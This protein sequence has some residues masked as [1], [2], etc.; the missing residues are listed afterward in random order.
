MKKVL[1]VFGSYADQRQ[2]FFD[3]YMSPRNQEYADKHGFE[4][5]ELKDDLYKYRGNY[6]WLKF[7]ILEQMLEEGYVTDGDIVTHL[8]A[9]MCIANID[10]LYQ[11]NK[12][13]SYSIDSGNTHCMGNYS[14]KVNEWSRQLVDNI[15]SEDR[16][17][18]L[19]DTVSRHERFGHVNSFW[20]EFR[21]QASWYS[22]AGI[23][24]HSD[25]PFWNLPN[26]GWH[27]DKTEWTE[28]S[29]D[30]L[31][32]HVEI[33]PTAWNVTEME[34]ESDCQ[35]LINRVE[36]DDVIIRHFA[37]GQKWREEWFNK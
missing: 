4:Y 17:Q 7:T 24:R 10:E 6:T 26:Y 9:D 25:E 34:G 14:I 8:D 21:E 31:Y 15:L 12:S 20:H 1:L 33:L 28:Y 37:G 5:L 22:L 3:T 29:L 2:Q 23:K 27:S 32:E 11:T 13:F 35:F 19:N 18:S 16:Y 36:K 30:E